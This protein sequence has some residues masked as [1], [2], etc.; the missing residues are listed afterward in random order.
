VELRGQSRGPESERE[1]VKDMEGKM[2]KKDETDYKG[3]NT[4]KIY[5]MHVWRNF[6][7]CT[8]HKC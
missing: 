4:I 3:I 8:I 1:T 2:G 6:L 7:I 5:Y